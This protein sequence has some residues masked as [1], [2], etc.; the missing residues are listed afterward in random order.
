MNTI[1]DERVI[2]QLFVD[3]FAYAVGV[4]RREG[5]SDPEDVAAQMFAA[6][7][8]R[9][10]DGAEIQHLRSYLAVSVKRE[11][12]RRTARERK[13]VPYEEWHSE[14]MRPDEWP[15]AH[16]RDALLSLPDRQRWV[17]Q[18][19]LVEGV[20]QRELA[21]R[22]GL[23]ANAISALVYRARTALRAAYRERIESDPER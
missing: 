13:S 15:D 23:S 11:T 17:L 7:M 22:V 14:V 2:A 1:V 3:H 18:L 19:V 16:L 8:D 12:W 20:S 21:E 4:A 9:L 10:K 6:T 5:A